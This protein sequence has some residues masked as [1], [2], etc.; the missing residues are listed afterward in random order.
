MSGKEKTALVATQK[1][2]QVNQFIQMAIEKN[3]P[4]ETMERLFALSREVKADQAK[5][6]FVSAMANFQ[7]EVKTIKKTKPVK[8]KDGTLRYMYAPID[9]IVE[10]IKKPL[11]DNNLSYSWESLLKEAEK[12]VLV[13]KN[14]HTEIE[15][16]LTKL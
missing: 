1:E 9:S 12:C 15:A 6:A 13:C 5:E 10:Q 2:T 16:G 11:A 8:S 4:V 3:L 7:K 14:C